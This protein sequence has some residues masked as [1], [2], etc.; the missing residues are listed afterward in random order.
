MGSWLAGSQVGRN[1][2]E[3]ITTGA[4]YLPLYRAGVGVL[5]GAE[6]FGTTVVGVL[7]ALV[8]E[9]VAPRRLVRE[10]SAE[11]RCWQ[12]VDDLRVSGVEAV[13]D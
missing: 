7:A 1:E 11:P 10:L 6:E 9:D 3:Q 12:V 4:D 13:Q 8:G 5:V 2:P